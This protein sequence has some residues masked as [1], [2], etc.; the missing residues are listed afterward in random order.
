[1]TDFLGISLDQVNAAAH[2]IILGAI[3]V[4]FYRIRSLEKIVGNGTGK[5]RAR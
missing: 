5:H 2:A 4:L 3:V 1:M